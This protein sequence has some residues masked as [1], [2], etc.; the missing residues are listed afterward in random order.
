MKFETL[1]T[2]YKNLGYTVLGLEPESELDSIIR[3][4][5]AEHEYL[6]TVRPIKGLER[7]LVNLTLKIKG[8]KELKPELIFSYNCHYKLSGD[9]DVDYNGLGGNSFATPFEVKFFA[10]KTLYKNLRWNYTALKK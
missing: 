6:I 9:M 3:W 10:L 5:Y 1:L 4:A 8:K 2:R 7:R